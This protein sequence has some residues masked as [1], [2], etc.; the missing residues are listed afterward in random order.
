MELL[1]RGVAHAYRDRAGA[2]PYNGMQ[3]IGGQQRGNQRRRGGVGSPAG[4]KYIK[5]REG[6]GYGEDKKHCDKT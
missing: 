2:L 1:T 5:S 3:D 6:S 4:G